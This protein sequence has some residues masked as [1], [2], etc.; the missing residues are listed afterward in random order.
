MAARTGAVS[1]NHAL[2]ERPRHLL[3]RLPHPL[4]Q[5]DLVVSHAEDVADGALF[6]ER[7][8]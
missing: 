8:K 3:Q 2:E 5:L 1:T 7:R 6:G 4:V